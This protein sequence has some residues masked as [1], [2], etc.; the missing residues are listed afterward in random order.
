ME[1]LA[2]TSLVEGLRSRRDSEAMLWCD[3]PGDPQCRPSPQE[4]E[5]GDYRLVMVTGNS[6]RFHQR[7]S[8]FLSGPLHPSVGRSLETD[9]QL[10]NY[11][12]HVELPTLQLPAP[13]G[14]SGVCIPQPGR[15]KSLSDRPRPSMHLCVPLTRFI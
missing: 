14:N 1:A 5:E 3:R 4:E 12:V 15:H 11:P 10:Y 7:L 9:S 8:L 13:Y 2:R 6:F